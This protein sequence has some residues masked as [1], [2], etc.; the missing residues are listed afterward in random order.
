MLELKPGTM[1]VAETGAVAVAVAVV[2]VT[3][4]VTVGN[5]LLFPS[6]FHCRK[7]FLFSSFCFIA[8][9]PF[10]S[11]IIA[12]VVRCPSVRRTHFLIL[13]FYNDIF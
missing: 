5:N 3:M 7:G 10:G 6:Q 4:A 11:H 12:S 1:T 2:V 9:P 13:V 8:A